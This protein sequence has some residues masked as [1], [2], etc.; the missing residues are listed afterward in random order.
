MLLLAA[1]APAADPEPTPNPTDAADLCSAI[2]EPG[3]A[4]EAITVE[5]EAGTAST[6]DFTAPLEFS[7]LQV[8]VVAEGEGEKAESGDFVAFAFSAYSA[9]TGEEIAT[10]GYT[11][12]D[13]MPSQVSAESALGQ[14]LGCAAPGQRVVATI[15]ASDSGEAEVYV[16]DVV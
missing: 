5:G 3:D 10:Y 4:S 15:P 1:C 13:L 7:D 11:P 6:L 9:T 12:G 8:S 2:A 16:I 14:M